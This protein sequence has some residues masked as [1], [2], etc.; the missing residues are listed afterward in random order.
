MVGLN[1][2][3]GVLDRKAC[4]GLRLVND[5]LA[6]HP[7]DCRVGQPTVVDQR[8]QRGQIGDP[9]AQQILGLTRQG[10][11][12]NHLWQ[13]VDQLNKA[14]RFV[15]VM[16]GYLHLNQGLHGQPKLRRIKARAVAYDEPLGL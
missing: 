15:G 2:R 12:A 1:D 13:A 8:V 7:R 11:T 10:P 16:G 9:D 3:A 14:R 5:D 4:I 6:L